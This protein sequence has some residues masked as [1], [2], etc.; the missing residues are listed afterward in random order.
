MTE[1]SFNK[2]CDM[3]NKY[4]LEAVKKGHSE[5]KSIETIGMM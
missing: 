3:L 1:S 4:S 5:V 2:T